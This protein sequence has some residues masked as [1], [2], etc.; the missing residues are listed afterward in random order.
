MHLRTQ[1]VGTGL[2]NNCQCLQKRYIS[3]QEITAVAQQVVQ[4]ELETQKEPKV[5]P[6]IRM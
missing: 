5:I 6:D 3:D 2:F 4:N 1:T